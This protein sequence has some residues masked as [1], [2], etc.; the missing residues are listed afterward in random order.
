MEEHFDVVDENDRVVGKAPRSEVHGKGRWHR[1]VYVF[2]FN[3]K[4]ELFIQQRSDSKDVEPGMWDCSVTGHPSSGEGYDEATVRE[5]EEE[6][7]VRVGPRRL[8]FI[9]YG[10]YHHHVWVYRAEHEGPFTLDPGEV[11]GGRFTS[12]EELEK[13]M[14]ENQGKYSPEFITI[15]RRF[16]ESGSP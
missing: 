1:A 5:A 6:I 9:K 8:F 15:F 14:E 2:V 11:K 13:D 10:P 7:G 4:G 12:L 16:T 3:S